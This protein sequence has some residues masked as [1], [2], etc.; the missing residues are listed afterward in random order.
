[1]GYCS[2]RMFGVGIWPLAGLLGLNNRG[3]LQRDESWRPHGE[4]GLEGDGSLVADDA[5]AID[6]TRHTKASDCP[7]VQAPDERRRAADVQFRDLLQR[8]RDVAGDEQRGR[9]LSALDVVKLP[10]RPGK[11][12]TDPSTNG[13]YR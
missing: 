7:L 8:T 13:L 12:V 2:S 11:A 3:R 1:M 4:S 9:H 5:T 6:C 10:A